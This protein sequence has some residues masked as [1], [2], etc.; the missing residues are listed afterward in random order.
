MEKDFWHERWERQEIGFHQNETNPFLAQHWQELRLAP[1]TKVFVPLCGKSL[2][3]LWLRG[4]GHAVLGVELSAIAAQAFFRENGCLPRRATSGNF[5]SYE[6]DD[7]RILCGDFFELGKDDLKGVSAVYDRASMVALP[8]GMRER[9]V[10]HLLGI[11]PPATKM[12]LLTF[13]YPQREMPGPPFAVSAEEVESLYKGRADIRL[14]A[15]H[16]TLDLN[17]RFRER[18]LTQLRESIFLLVLNR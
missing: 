1:G 10:R 7:I 2:D 4:H 18:G 12:L 6:A 13:D 14:L 3:M 15:Q 9:Y 17:A 5:E 8:P 16:D 11:L